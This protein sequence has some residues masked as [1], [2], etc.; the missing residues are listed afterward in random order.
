[1]LN[2][3]KKGNKSEMLGGKV[4]ASCLDLISRMLEFNPA[5]RLSIEEVLKHEY[6]AEFYDEKEMKQIKANKP[7]ITLHISDNTKL[8]T[9]DY[10]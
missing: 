4:S 3:R 2:V 1:M 7:K 5:K 6:L 9:K 10:R 8:T